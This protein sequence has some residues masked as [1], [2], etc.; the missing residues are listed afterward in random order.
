M[1][2]FRTFMITKFFAR[3]FIFAC[4][5]ASIAVISVRGAEDDRKLKISDGSVFAPK[6]YYPDFSWETTPR[7]FMFGDKARV[8][9]PEQVKY[10]S[11]QTSFLCIE[12]S[13]GMGQL[14]TA[15]IGAKHE[16]AA[17]K[18]ANP[19]AKVLFYFNA[20][21]AW[22]YTSYNERFSNKSLRENPEF[23][24]LLVTDPKNNKL[25]NRYG[26]YCYDVL[27]PNMRKWWVETVAKA[28]DESGCDG[29]FI[30]QMHGNV[31][32][33]KGKAEEIA[34]AM[35]E[36]MGALKK[37]MDPDKILLANNAYSES[38]KHVYPV[39]DA[40]MFENY[41]R[42]KSN[43][44]SLLTEWKHML[45]MAKDGKITVFRLG[46]EG[47]W[48]GNMKPNMSKLSKEKL[49]F[50]HACY[51]IGAQPYSY[52]MYSWG[53]KLGTGPLVDYPSLRKPVGSPKGAYVRKDSDGWEFTREFENA[54]VWVDT[55]AREAKI[56]WHDQN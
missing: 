17:F 31:D 15:E 10:I 27:N 39:S 30:D 28:V 24:K 5:F 21:F 19:R 3:K 48:R 16:A 18:K 32:Y 26:A 51:L 36:M 52:F 11:E 38:S 49:E 20:A 33:R 37:R 7:Y 1:L 8:L 34:V 13:H 44:E 43:K 9:R 35:G 40:I 12:K 53:W 56:T 55:E 42:Q 50:A 46:V 4:V 45:R 29:V 23:K 6:D 25:A 22:P 2:W 14:G 41:A 54:S 47:T